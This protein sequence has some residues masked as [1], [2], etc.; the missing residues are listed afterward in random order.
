[1]YSSVVYLGHY[2]QCMQLCGMHQCSFFFCLLTIRLHSPFD[3][4]PH[5]YSSIFGWEPSCIV[6]LAVGALS[7]QFIC[8]PGTHLC[9]S[10]VSQMLDRLSSPLESRAL[11]HA[12]PMSIWDPFIQIFRLLRPVY[13]IHLSLGDP[14]IQFLRLLRSIQLLCLETRRYRY[15]N[16]AHI[17][18]LSI[19]DSPIQCR[20]LLLI[21]PPCANCWLHSVHSHLQS[22]GKY[23]C[24]YTCISSAV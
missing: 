14:L 17:I 4:W 7:I 23:A 3:I 10:F 15:R 22:F 12:V 8:F 2:V 1:M 6:A 9:S 5:L 13:I 20:C 19:G 18:N 21:C 11:I 16:I 24:A